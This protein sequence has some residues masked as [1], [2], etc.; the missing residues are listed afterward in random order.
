MSDG[1]AHNDFVGNPWHPFLRVLRR[2]AANLPPERRSLPIRTPGTDPP[3]TWDDLFRLDPAV[4]RLVPAHGLTEAE[5]RALA[6]WLGL[7]GEERTSFLELGAAFLAQRDS[8][9]ELREEPW[10]PEDEGPLPPVGAAAPAQAR[11][12]EDAIPGMETATTASD[13]LLLLCRSRQTDLQRL[14]RAVAR[15]VPDLDSRIILLQ[16]RGTLPVLDTQVLEAALAI[17]KAQPAVA[18]RARALNRGRGGAAG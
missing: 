2:R 1:E 7:H 11:P 18:V 15:L 3:P 5:I 14:S 9:R 8:L 16:L 17:L 10:L 13:C 6:D 12:A 4:G